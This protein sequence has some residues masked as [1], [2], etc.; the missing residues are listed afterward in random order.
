MNAEGQEM[1]RVSQKPFGLI[2]KTSQPIIPNVMG[3]AVPSQN[4]VLRCR[5][6]SESYRAPK[7]S[8]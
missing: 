2:A 6:K 5:L 1:K 3:R 4:A 7:K 8:D